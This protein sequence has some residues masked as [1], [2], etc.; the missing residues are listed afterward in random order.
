[1]MT[2]LSYMIKNGW[3]HAKVFQYLYHSAS[4][5]NMIFHHSSFHLH[6]KIVSSIPLAHGYP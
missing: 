2:L 5:D 6:C 3:L 1:M 4:A